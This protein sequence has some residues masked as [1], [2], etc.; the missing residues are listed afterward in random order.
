MPHGTRLRPAAHGAL[1]LIIGAAGAAVVL[2]V[3]IAA[4]IALLALRGGDRPGPP[5]AS[6][7]KPASSN[8]NPSFS[9]SPG[10]DPAPSEAPGSG[11]AEGRRYALLVGVAQYPGAKELRDLAYPDRDMIDLAQALRANG[12]QADN[13][14]LMTPS[15]ET[16]MLRFLPE[17]KRIQQELDLLLKDRTAD[18]VVLLAFTGHGVK[19]K[20]DPV[21][22]FCPADAKLDDKDTLVSLAEVYRQLEG[23]KAGLKVLLVDA[24]PNDPLVSGSRAPD[25]LDLE[26]ARG[27]R[28][29]RRRAGWRPFLAARTRR[30]LTKPTSCI[31]V[32]SSIT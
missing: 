17:K 25:R 30:R 7:D 19:F 6:A 20:D 10:S 9:K 16:A 21:S 26:S 13:T 27:R 23:C 1:P 3:L 29:R 5:Q 24:C 14:V 18:D 15:T 2:F 4:G 22:Y 31:T 11:P 28:R 32:S 8:P 12:Y